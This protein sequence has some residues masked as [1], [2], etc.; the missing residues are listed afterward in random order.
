MFKEIDELLLS[1]RFINQR[2]YWLNELSL[3]TDFERTELLFKSGKNRE[4]EKEIEKVE[5]PIS[6]ELF[7]RLMKLGKQ[8][9]LSLYIILLTALKILIFRYTQ[10]EDVIITSSLYKGNIT[11]KTLND[12]VFI[13]NSINGDSTFI[14]LLLEIRKSVLQAYENQDY[15]HEKMIENLFNSS[16][17]GIN[18]STH[19]P[20]SDFICLLSNIHDNKMIKNNQDKDKLIFSFERKE[21]HLDGHILYDGNVY[22]KTY[23]HL[24]SKHFVRILENSTRDV[25]IKISD[26]SFSSEEEDRQ[27]IIDFN[28]TREAYPKEKTLVELFEEQVER[29]PGK[30]GV[31]YLDSH[32]T[33]RELN[34]KANQL[35][36][37]LRAKQVKAES[38]V[39]LMVERSPEMIIGVLAVLKAG[40]AFLPIDNGYPEVRKQYILKECG[41]RVLL[42]SKRTFH[43]EKK[44]IQRLSIKEIISVDDE[45]HYS[46]EAANLPVLHTSTNLSY[47]IYTS[48]TSGK[49]K[50]VMVN[51]HSLVNYTRWAGQRYVKNEAVNFPLYTSISFD[52]TLTS[53]FIPLLT[54]NAV[55]IYGEEEREPLTGQIIPENKVGVV[56]LTPSHLELIKHV[57]KDEDIPPHNKIKCFVVGG[58]KLESKLALDIYM[59]F[60][61]NIEIYNE[62]GPTEA[63]VGCMIYRFD[64]NY[65]HGTSVPIGNP[66]NN[67]H[68][69]I[70]DKDLRPVSFG[71]AGELCIGGAGIA[72]GYLNRVELTSEKF[73]KSPFIKKESLYRSGDLARRLLDGNIEF[74]GRMDKQVKIR[75]YRIELDE[76][77]NQLL[78]Y[79]AVKEAVVIAREFKN[80]GDDIDATGDKKYLCAYIVSG[81]KLESSNLKEHLSKEL[82]DYMIPLYFVYIDRLPLTLNGKVDTKTLP[83]PKLKL[84]SGYVSPRDHLEEELVKIWAE[85]LAV[86]TGIIGIDTNFFEIGGNSLNAMILTARIHKEFNVKIP[87][88]DIFKAPVIR[89]LADS[90]KRLKKDRYYSMKCAEKKEYYTLS[91][92]QKRLYVLQQIDLQSI[93]YNIPQCF[94][95]EGPLDMEKLENIFLQLI[96]RHESLRTSFQIINE[97]PMQRLSEAFDFKIE[98][99]DRRSNPNSAV[100]TLSD[101]L[102]P[103]DLSKTP[104]LRVRLIKEEEERHILMVDMHHII[105]DKISLEIFTQEFAALYAGKTLPKLRLQYKDYSQWENWFFKSRGI[106]KQEKFWLDQ[107]EGEIPELKFPYDYERPEVQDYEGDFIRGEIGTVETRCLKEI[108]TKNGATLNMI[109]LTIFEV[110]LAKHTDQEDIVVGIPVSGRP[111]RDLYHIIG[112]FV[113]MLALR[114]H[115]SYKKRFIDLMEEVKEGFVKALDNQ[116]YQ[117]DTLI[118][119]LKLKRNMNRNPLFDVVFQF[120][121][122]EP[123]QWGIPPELKMELSIKVYGG[124]FTISKFDLILTIFEL[125]DKIT[126]KFEY[127]RRLFKKSTLERMSS[128]FKCIVAEVIKNPRLE[129]YKI[130]II[131]HRER[132]KIKEIKEDKPGLFIKEGMVDQSAAEPENLKINFNF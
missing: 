105:S 7:S 53:I 2:G 3:G 1:S 50:G 32:L 91:S 5:I 45:N 65:D 74:V 106:N 9:D 87:L 49:P 69:Y 31:V 25:K 122:V 8:S 24:I 109:L 70:L 19:D 22:E 128:S 63:T 26:V 117:F 118:D 131:K 43:E 42:M 108:A 92:P 80:A 114:N 67:T 127:S 101:F 85:I 30:V 86:E 76:I 123:E 47:I 95:L 56:K 102:R 66:I 4:S 124:K 17:T 126:Y 44:K 110:L 29:T 120:N 20:L 125:K 83:L 52:L 79:P 13:R 33:Y 93:S 21:N 16:Q 96:R 64:P 55:V 78:T 37:H 82:P 38:I 34:K 112:M 99:F 72:R 51:H 58:E 18:K 81:K 111:H 104:L 61:G 60:N 129:I 115:P 90:L 116:E 130:E 48:G 97:D 62:Y 73:I 121:N 10:N 107:F 119:R 54:G 40:G 6:E 89:K 23:L 75:G 46:G 39:G 36:R 12:R 98:Y 77:E 57:F 94:I 132:I 68:I 41:T 113:N 100:S 71:I 88:E 14:Q 27:F 28:Q 103:F 11:A 84:G 59:K 35:A 15:P